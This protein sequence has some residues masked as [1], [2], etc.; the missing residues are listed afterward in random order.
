MARAHH[1]HVR[2]AESGPQLV[3]LG[4]GQSV[5]MVA[6]LAL[7]LTAAGLGVY[8]SAYRRY[9]QDFGIKKFETEF[10]FHTGLMEWQEPGNAR[11]LTWGIVAVTPNG[12]F[13]R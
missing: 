3:R 11:E 1:P 9:L 4:T 10:G 12:A 5:V 13:A 6:G 8:P 2:R 7:V